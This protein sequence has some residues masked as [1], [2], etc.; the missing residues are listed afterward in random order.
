MSETITQSDNLRSGNFG[1]LRAHLFGDSA[2]RLADDLQQTN[3]RE[4][5]E[6]GGCEVCAGSALREQDGLLSVIE[7]VAQC[8]RTTIRLAHIAPLPPPAHARG[9]TDSRTAACLG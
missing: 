6:S 5:Q 1:M 4:I 9:K 3:Q 2:R 7:H 8:R